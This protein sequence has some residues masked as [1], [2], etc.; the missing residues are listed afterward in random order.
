[1]LPRI[2]NNVLNSH[3]WMF[4]LYR[5]ARNFPWT[6]FVKQ[7]GRTGREARFDTSPALV[8]TASFVFHLFL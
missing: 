1:M 4:C 3:P 8:F 2:P 5:Y 6:V 7:L